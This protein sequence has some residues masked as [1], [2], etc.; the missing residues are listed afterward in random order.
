MAGKSRYWSRF[1]GARMNRRRFLVGSSSLGAG[2]AT[3]A[4]VG[5]GNDDDGDDPS[6]T[7]SGQST[8]SNSQEPAPAGR[9]GSIRTSNPANL[10]GLDPIFGSGGDEQPFL[11]TV[12]DNLMAYDADLVPSMERSLASSWELVDPVTIRFTLRPDIQ[13]HDGTPLNSEAVN[14]HFERG[15]TH[16]KAS[17]K[18][19]LAAIEEV[20][21]VSDVDFVIHMS[22]PFSPLLGVLGDRAGMITSPTAFEELGDDIMRN[23][24]GAGAFRFV[25]EVLDDRLVV[26]AWDDYYR[27]DCPTI[28]GVRWTLGVPPDQAV[29]GMLTGDFNFLWNPDTTKLSDLEAAGNQVRTKVTN[30]VTNMWLNP[31]MEPFTN[32]HLRRAVNWGVNREQ[33]NDIVYGGVHTPAHHGWLGPAT[34]VWHDPD[35]EGYTY[36]PDK[37]REELE[38]AGMP[39]G[40]SFDNAIPGEPVAI[41]QGEVMQANLAEF[42]IQM[43]LL[44][45]AGPQHYLG[46]LEH[47]WPAFSAGATVRADPWQQMAFVNRK[48]GLWT[49]TL[50]EGGDPEAEQLFI[51]A[52]AVYDEEER[53]PRMQDLNR[54]LEDL[55]WGVK[56]V[57]VSAVQAAA[58]GIEFQDFLD[59]KPHFGQ[60]DIR[61][62]E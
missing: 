18:S 46:F 58:P 52:A 44:T 25:E 22:E 38:L 7:P 34:G 62:T 50:P 14:A 39:E 54:R 56:I 33:V 27:S 5:C 47:S 15:R 59:G 42:G 26:E 21:V 28:E 12:H 35:F 24:V 6:V 17:T 51:E 32:E 23:P 41:A 49:A 13:F 1:Q 57:Y 8:P 31:L 30:Q 37:V 3:L 45:M 9:S 10:V 16:E 11:W 20:E 19:D 36:N 48:D 2:A 60:C 61:I 43:N 55:A 29:N 4:L 40:F 53:Y